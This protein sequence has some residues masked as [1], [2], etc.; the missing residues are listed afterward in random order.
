MYNSGFPIPPGFCIT[1]KA[2]KDFLDYNELDV[3]VK[4][5]LKGL[6][7][8]DT[9]LLQNVSRQ[10][11]E[12]IIEAELPENLRKEILDAYED[13]S[14]NAELF[15]TLKGTALDIIRATKEHPYVAVRSS[16]TAEDLPNASF[17]GQ[18]RTFL[19]VKGSS[20]LLKAVSACFA[21]LY[22]ARAIYYREKKG[23]DHSKVY[24]SV[25]VQKQILSDVS[26]VL[27]TVNPVSS[28]P[29]EVVIEAGFGLGEAVVSGA[30]TP[31]MYI[32]DKES[33]GIKSKRVNKQLWRLALDEH[34]KKTMRK[35]LTEEKASSQKLSD[36]KI[37]ELVNICKKI[38]THYGKPQDIEFAIESGKVYIVQ[39]R[40]ITTLKKPSFMREEKRP[41]QKITGEKP[42][43]LSQEPFLKGL[44][45]SPGVASGKVRILA[46]ASKISE[47]EEGEILVTRMTTPDFVPAMERA[48]AILT[49]EGGMTS[50]AAIVSREME[51]PCI[52][53]SIEATKKLHD[54]QLITVDA[55]NG[56]VFLG[57]LEMPAEKKHVESGKV[58]DWA[59]G[60]GHLLTATKIYMNLG[61]P[62]K[63]DEYKSLDFDGIGLMRIEF[64]VSG[65]GVHPKFLIK[66]GRGGEYVKGLVDGISHVAR[67]ISPRPVIVRFSDF[68][69]NEFNELEGGAEFEIK[70]ANPMI[71]WRGVS[72]YIDPDFKDVFML[73][74]K[75]ISEVRS[76]GLKNVWVMLPFVRKISEVPPTLSIMRDAGLVR[77]ESF[78][79]FLMAEVPSM[80]FV[81]EKF[82]ELDVDGASIGSNDLTQMVLGVDRDSAKLGRSG[83]F[84]ENDVAV[85]KAIAS[86]IKGFKKEGK[87]VSI[88]G[89]A[90]SEYPEF[91]DFLV[92]W[93]IDSISV[94]PDVVG[95][96][97]EQV[98]MIE[99]KILLDKAIGEK[100]V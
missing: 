14:V 19:N 95:K 52:V 7:V 9:E 78:K 69:T 91:V 13:M 44:G 21:S 63:I 27:F 48:G 1:A 81:P 89:Q 18:Q 93:G 35:Q 75:A 49:D 24:L 33:G 86:I 99:R 98:A 76:Q 53:G 47:L 60:S 50:H 58:G 82:A 85:K 11:Q 70:E 55:D 79:I 28:N 83:Y 56:L 29:S 36:N 66:E 73:E 8:E 12:R 30:I 15:K 62:D 97:R 10:I 22:T 46:D 38:E 16:A 17:A 54:G 68:R 42:R 92:R 65:L 25:I 100:Q 59:S 31:D 43:S 94:N 90:P 72:R 74:C 5:L 88:C 45:A 84:D 32:V 61:E 26:G 41:V 57:T 40:P 67:I 71:G 20:N 51:I 39:S 64:I 2:F 77:G 4:R 6:N 87:V 34:L 3:E 23:F 96:V 80:A 37:V